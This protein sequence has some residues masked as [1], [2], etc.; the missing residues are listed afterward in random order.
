MYDVKSC[1][2]TTAELSIRR[3]QQFGARGWL[4]RL[5]RGMSIDPP[6]HQ[7]SHSKVHKNNGR[8]VEWQQGRHGLHAHGHHQPRG[9]FLGCNLRGGRWLWSTGREART[10][11]HACANK[12]EEQGIR[13]RK[14]VE[15]YT[16][17]GHRGGE[18]AQCEHEESQYRGIIVKWLAF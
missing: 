4:R 7:S 2:R 1:N 8:I 5:G 17:E 12:E 11:A 6:D 9:C 15:H 14:A 10:K 16:R 13:G 18:Q 3:G